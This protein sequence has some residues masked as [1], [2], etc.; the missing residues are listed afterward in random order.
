ME[1]PLRDA[2]EPTRPPG[3][4]MDLTAAIHTALQKWNGVTAVSEGAPAKWRLIEG[5]SGGGR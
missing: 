2:M 3:Q 1:E 5:L 4:F